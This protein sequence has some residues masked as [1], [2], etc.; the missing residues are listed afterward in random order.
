MSCKQGVVKSDVV[1][2][3]TIRGRKKIFE[4]VLLLPPPSHP[5]KVAV[6]TGEITGS[7]IIKPS[8]LRVHERAFSKKDKLSRKLAYLLN[9]SHW[10]ESFFEVSFKFLSLYVWF[11]DFFLKS[12]LKLEVVHQKL[13]LK[14]P[15]T[16][17]MDKNPTPTLD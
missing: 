2:S 1:K 9:T 6:K 12:C 10:A 8:F 17:H 3:L 16:S 7:Y 13:D 15:V 11:H 5:R 4:S 14:K